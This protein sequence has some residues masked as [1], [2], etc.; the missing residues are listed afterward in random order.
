[1][2]IDTNILLSIF[3]IGAILVAAKFLWGFNNVLRSQD[4]AI[5]AQSKLISDQLNVVKSY[6]SSAALLEKLQGITER[7]NKPEYVE[8]IVDQHRKSIEKKHQAEISELTNY[9]ENK[10][11]K[12]DVKEAKL[13]T[14][15]GSKS[16]IPKKDT[17]SSVEV[18]RYVISKFN[19]SILTED[20]K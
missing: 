13:H 14:A 12:R 15:S 3:E 19:K 16:P 1:M 2:Y 11:T 9:Y 6:E 20:E 7:I 8:M 4:K 5:Q 10:S 18:N 17:P